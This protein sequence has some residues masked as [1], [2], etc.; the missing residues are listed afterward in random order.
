VL[1]SPRRDQRAVSARR[2]PSLGRERARATRQGRPDRAARTGKAAARPPGDSS[3]GESAGPG[4]A[5]DP[6]HGEP[7]DRFQ[8]A[9]DLRSA[10]WSKPPKPGGTAGAERD[11]ERGNSG[12]GVA[13]RRTAS[14]LGNGPGGSSSEQRYHREWTPGTHADGGADFDNPKRGARGERK[15]TAKAARPERSAEANPG[16]ARRT[17]SP[18]ERRRPRGLGIG[19]PDPKR[20]RTG[21]PS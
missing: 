14:S 19:R 13:P 10:R 11:S 8:G 1:A 4:T 6:K 7:Q 18:M 3:P 5:H 17:V 12:P 16:S 9:T 2:R 21:S 20:A 15:A